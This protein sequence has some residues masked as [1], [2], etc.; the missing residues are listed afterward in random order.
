MNIG[1]ALYK[2]VKYLTHLSWTEP[3]NEVQTVFDSLKHKGTAESDA[4]TDSKDCVIQ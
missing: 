1:A 3:M 4:G 2:D